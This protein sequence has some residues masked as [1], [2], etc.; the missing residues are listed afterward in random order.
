MAKDFI[1]PNI[2]DD[3]DLSELIVAIDDVVRIAVSFDM[4]WTTRGTGRSYDSLTGMAV[5]I[6]YFTKK[7]LTYVCLNRKC[8]QCDIGHK[9][10]DHDCRKNFKGSA[11]L[12]EPAAAER[13]ALSPWLKNNNVDIGLMVTDGDSLAI[14][15]VRNCVD[16]EI[17]HQNDKNHVSKGLKSELFK[18]K[19]NSK[20][21][22]LSSETITYLHRCFTYCI[23][24][25]IGDSIAMANAIKNIPDHCFNHHDNCGP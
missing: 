14:N 4:G 1:I 6:G 16:H 5:L 9:A 11:K 23:S 21:K 15:A 13:L 24:Q 3:V 19:K 20:F 8:R 2:S 10:G 17:A 7:V 22:E 18:L 12:M 25:N